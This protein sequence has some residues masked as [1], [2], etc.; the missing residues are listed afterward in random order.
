M[1]LQVVTK[2]PDLDIM[3]NKSKMHTSFLFEYEKL[4]VKVKDVIVDE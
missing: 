4:S 3:N 1:S 2:C